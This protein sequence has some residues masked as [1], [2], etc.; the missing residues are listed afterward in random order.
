LGLHCNG[1]TTPHNV[2]PQGIVLEQLGC[3][4]D[5]KEVLLLQCSND[6]CTAIT[7]AP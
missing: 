2:T 5:A 3:V 1:S 7:A 4:V 6:S